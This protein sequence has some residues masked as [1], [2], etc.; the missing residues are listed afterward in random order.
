M[1]EVLDVYHSHSSPKNP[2]VCMEESTKQLLGE[3]RELLP[4]EL[5]Q[6]IRYNREYERHG[7]GNWFLAFT[8]LLNWRTVTV[9]GRRTQLD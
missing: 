8:P 4:L 7:M 2:L 9:T 6:L 5:G 1:E 3:T